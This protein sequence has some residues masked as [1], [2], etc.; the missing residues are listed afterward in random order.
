MFFQ[1]DPREIE[2]QK[3]F[4]PQQMSGRVLQT[5]NSQFRRMGNQDRCNTQN[6]SEIKQKAVE[7]SFQFQNQA[8]DRG[9]EQGR[10]RQGNHILHQNQISP[11]SEPHSAALTPYRK[12]EIALQFDVKPTT[13]ALFTRELKDS[14]ALKAP[15][16]QN[17]MNIIDKFAENNGGLDFAN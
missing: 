14:E 8:Y 5:K 11:A 3:D 12:A 15:Q 6:S 17:N 2:V 7:E 4:E 16:Q 10:G 9:V 13:T 1:T